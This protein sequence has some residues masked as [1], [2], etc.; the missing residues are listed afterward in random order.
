MSPRRF[1][2][3]RHGTTS[4]VAIGKAVPAELEVHLVC[5]N[6]ATHKTPLVHD[7]PARHPHFHP[8][9]FVWS[10]AAEEILDSLARYL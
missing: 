8:K 6:L 7:W 5:G 4:L 1:D 2:D 9:P 3:S 10:K